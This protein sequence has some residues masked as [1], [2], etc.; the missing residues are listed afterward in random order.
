MESRYDEFGLGTD[1]TF[2]KQCEP[3]GNPCESNLE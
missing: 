3:N 1:K 2:L